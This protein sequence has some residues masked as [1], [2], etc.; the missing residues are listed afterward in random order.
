MLVKVYSK[1]VIVNST[2]SELSSLDL[3]EATELSL[4]PSA[5]SHFLLTGIVTPSFTRFLSVESLISTKEVEPFVFPLPFLRGVPS[6]FKVT[7]L[8]KLI[9]APILRYNWNIVKNIS[10]NSHQSYYEYA[11]RKFYL[12]Y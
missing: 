2:L 7:I 3:F 11:D 6:L 9:Y 5:F 8:T 12:H 4:Y 1:F 10:S